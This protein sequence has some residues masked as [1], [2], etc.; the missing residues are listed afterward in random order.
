MKTIL[1]ADDEES[2]RL[3]IGTTLEGAEY[4]LLEATD[5]P[6]TLETARAEHPDLI[7]LDWMMPGKSGIEVARELRT[8]PATA[9]IPLLML[10]A[11]GQEKDRKLGLAAGVQAYLVK[12]FSPLE[13][14]DCV[15]E[16]LR[17]AEFCR[18]ESADAAGQ[19]YRKTA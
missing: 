12:P 6:A 2:L 19:P 15:E 17:M 9:S 4:R 7:I 5:G 18:G 13:L 3:L 16:V 8:D 1:I 14:L 10:T 11:M